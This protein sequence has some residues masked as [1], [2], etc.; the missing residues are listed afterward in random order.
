MREITEK[1]LFLMVD[2]AAHGVVKRWLERGDG[3]AVYQNQALD[4][5]NCGHRK[6]TSYG[7]TVAQLEVIDPP[8]RMPDI[9]HGPTPWAYRLEGVCRRPIPTGPGADHMWLVHPDGGECPDGC[10]AAADPVRGAAYWSHGLKH[11]EDQ[12]SLMHEHEAEEDCP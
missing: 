10:D 2:T 6:F 5:A 11:V 9:D 8:E 4:S 7:S 1:E 3:V 12:P